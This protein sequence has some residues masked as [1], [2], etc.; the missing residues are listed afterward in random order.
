MFGNQRINWLQY[1]ER[2]FNITGN[3]SDEKPKRQAK[4]DPFL[5]TTWE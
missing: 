1:G 3:S 5:H 4:K 2:V